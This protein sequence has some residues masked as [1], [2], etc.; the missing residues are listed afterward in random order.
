RRERAREVLQGYNVDARV[1]EPGEALA[2]RAE[3]R[4]CARGRKHCRRVREERDEDGLAPDLARL[5]SDPR[6]DLLVTAMNA[7]EVSERDNWGPETPVT[8]LE[9]PDDL[10]RGA[11]APCVR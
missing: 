11:S 3:R 5:T 1:A 2:Q 4:G 8:R 9:M 7:I 6:Q 10:H